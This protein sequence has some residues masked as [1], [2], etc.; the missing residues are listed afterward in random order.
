MRKILALCIF[1]LLSV[2]A[3]SACT[4]TGT[5][6]PAAQSVI[7]VLC[8]VDSV[9]QP[10]AV[11]VAPELAP[12]LTPVTAIDAALVHP[13]VVSACKAVNGAPASVTVA[14]ATPPAPMVAPAPVVPVP[15][16]PAVTPAPAAANP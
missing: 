6:T 11:T 15:A 13:A 12:E 4:S 7:T 3:M 10:V 14:P 5:L 2:S 9:G 1:A 8:N 16:T